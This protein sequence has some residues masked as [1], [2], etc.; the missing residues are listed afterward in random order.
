LSLRDWRPGIAWLLC[1]QCWRETQNEG[2]NR[3]WPE[4]VHQVG[5]YPRE[6]EGIGS[7]L[8]KTIP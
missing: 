2:E 5:T 8:L 6:I 3:G 7:K 4:G 1:S